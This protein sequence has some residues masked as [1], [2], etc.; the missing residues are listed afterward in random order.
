MIN[1]KDKRCKC[2]KATPYFNYPGLKAEYCSECKTED[3][4]NVK[5]KRCKCGDTR[6][7][8][9]YPGLKAEYCSKC[10]TKDM[11]DVV[12]K[13]VNVAKPNHILIIQD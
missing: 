4:I 10:K 8:F 1:V 13:D 12:N 11:V 6:P 3:M 7:Y 9:N 2:K 5:D